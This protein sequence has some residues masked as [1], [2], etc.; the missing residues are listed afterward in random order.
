MVV[1]Q[2]SSSKCPTCG[3]P[4]VFSGNGRSRQCDRCGY[5]ETVA[6]KG[7][8]LKD[9]E[10]VQKLR[11]RYDHLN[12]EDGRSGARIRLAEGRELVRNGRREDAYDALT[13]VLKTQ[14][15]DRERAEAW[16]WL[17]HVFRDESERRSCL[18]HALALNPGNGAARRDLAI[19]D[20]RIAADEVIDPETVGA[21]REAKVEAAQ[22]QQHACPRCAGAMGY[23]AEQQAYHC[24]FCG[25]T[26]T[27]AEYDAREAEGVF[28]KGKYEQDFMAALVTAQGHLAPINL[29]VLHCQSCA[30]EFMLS[31]ETLSVTCP[32]C[33]SVFVTDAAE[34]SEII[35]PHALLPFAVDQGAAEAKMRRWLKQVRL[36][37]T[38]IAPLYGVYQPVWT[39]DVGG[40]IKWRGVVEENERRVPVSGSKLIFF[41]DVLVPGCRHVTKRQLQN[42]RAF[43]L[44]Q[45]EPYDAR[46]LAQWPAERYTLPLA[47][48]SLKGRTRV[49]QTLRKNP[50]KLTNRGGRVSQ[51]QINTQS[52]I[53]ESFK[54]LLLPV[55]IGHYVVNETEF[56]VTINGQNGVVVAERPS[57]LFN[58]LRSWLGQS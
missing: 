30:T 52:V 36:A 53:V 2:S 43:D 37:P 31:P 35:P 7:P 22:V 10:Y 51:L 57:G 58:T 21:G 48:A 8:S 11:D 29:R 32:Y 3:G 55:W 14:S 49:L 16:Y 45:I 25:L 47:D 28:G 56:E 23:N 50:R 20:G 33:Q 19:L 6:A 5:S 18:E 27:V 15:T 13:H 34:S 1:N 44:E 4:L 46:Y 41:D 42:F 24:A 26:E 12:D 9:L 38:R 17:S 40:E 54:L 39:F